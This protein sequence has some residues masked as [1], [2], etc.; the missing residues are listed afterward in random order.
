VTE[1][2]MD[3]SSNNMVAIILDILGILLV[4]VGGLITYARSRSVVGVGLFWI[5][6]ILLVISLIL[7]IWAMMKKPMMQK[8]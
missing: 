6:I 4:I 3:S 2:Q 7:F 5:G 8:M 1:K